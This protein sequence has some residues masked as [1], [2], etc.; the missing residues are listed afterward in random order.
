MEYNLGVPVMAQWKLISVGIMRSRV[1]SLASL[2]QLRIWCC[3]ELW[4][5]S[6]TQLDPDLLWLWHRP[7]TVAPIEPLDWAPPYAAGMALKKIK[8]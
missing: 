5:R 4:C 6:Q 3:R 7:A 1:Q 2:S 8:K